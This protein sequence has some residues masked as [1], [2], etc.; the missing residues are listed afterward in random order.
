MVICVKISIISIFSPFLWFYIMILSHAL[1]LPM[2]QLQTEQVLT[3]QLRSHTEY[4]IYTVLLYSCAHFLVEIDENVA[5][6][7]GFN[8]I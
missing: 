6:M 5:L 1:I 2:S 8:A 3:S 7:A 4:L